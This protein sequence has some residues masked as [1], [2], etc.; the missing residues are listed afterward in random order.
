MKGIDAKR[1]IAATLERIWALAKK[2]PRNLTVMFGGTGAR[3]SF[4]GEGRYLKARVQ[5]PALDD[6]AEINQAHF[7]DIIGYVLHEFAHLLYTKNEPWES[8]IVDRPELRDTKLPFWFVNSLEDVRIEGLLIQSG[9]AANAKA[10]FEGLIDGQDASEVPVDIAENVPYVLAVEGRRLNNDYALTTP[11]LLADCPWAAEVR[12]TLDKLKL[13]RS[14]ADTVK[15][16]IALYDSLFDDMPPIER[17]PRPRGKKGEGDDGE[18]VEGEELVGGEG[19]GGGEGKGRKRTGGG[20]ASS[21]GIPEADKILE[22]KAKKVATSKDVFHL[23]VRTKPRIAK[24][25]FED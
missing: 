2:E 25:I 8:L 13:A 3:C 19:G 21:K 16:A 9:I 12:E 23:P 10:L 7:N 17:P 11:D 6:V 20:G 1:G 4:E 5:L 24:I 15:I 18:E 14:T 22:G